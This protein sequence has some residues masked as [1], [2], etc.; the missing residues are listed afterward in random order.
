MKKISK[1]VLVVFSVIILLIGVAVNLLIVGWLDY[2]TAFSLI[3]RALSESP[4]NKI[5]LIFTELSM[6]FAILCIFLDSSEKGESKSSGRDV[7]MQN[8]NGKLM[9]SRE[10]IEN[11]VNGVVKEFPGARQAQTRIAL[12]AQNNVDVL[13]DL[14]VT[15]DVVIKELT[16]NMQT[17]IKETIKKT[18]DLEVNQ[19]N[20]RIKNIVSADSEE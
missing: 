2:E 12:D 9:I 13:V 20:V 19:V 7:L 11:L 15:K 6:L 3:R 8:D 17:R 5:I 16:A 4:S 1:L 10:T 14:T 18:S